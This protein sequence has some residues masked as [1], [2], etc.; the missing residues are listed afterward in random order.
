MPA[1]F[2]PD[3]PAGFVAHEAAR[4]PWDPAMMH[5][6]APAALLARAIEAAEP[7]AGMFTARLTV[8]FLGGVPL[9]P[10]QTATEV[11]KPG[12]RFQLV[13]ATLDAGGRRA[14]LARAVRLRRGELP[15]PAPPVGARGLPGPGEAAELQPFVSSPAGSMFHPDAMEIRVAGGELGS[16]V[17][18]AW[19]RMRG[20]LLPGE[21]P[22]PLARVAAAA[23]FTNGLSWILPWERY[24]FVNTDLTIHLHREAQGEWIGLEARTDVDDAG[25]GLARGRLHDVHGPIGTCAQTLFV[26]AR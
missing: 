3:P 6:G 21:A 20:D 1:L 19:L 4:G 5:G 10:V 26:A 16:G 17:L 23:D 15:E 14:C 2:T 9:G 7:G 25:T 8:E 22:T 13:E 11:V 24:L 12:R 18:D